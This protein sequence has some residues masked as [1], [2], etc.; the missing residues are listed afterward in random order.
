MIILEEIATLI[1]LLKQIQ[2]EITVVWFPEYARFHYYCGLSVGHFIQ[3]LKLSK[4]I[5]RFTLQNGVFASKFSQT[6]VKNKIMFK[7]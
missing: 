5:F 6:L 1:E 4:T 3:C 2:N 7:K